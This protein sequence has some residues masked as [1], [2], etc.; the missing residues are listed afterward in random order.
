MHVEEKKNIFRRVSS[1][2]IYFP[3]T[4]SQK[5]SE[6][7]VPSRQEIYPRGEV[8]ETSRMFTKEDPRMITTQ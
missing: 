3:C 5:V 7:G 8:K 1:P 2:K 4:L 6:D